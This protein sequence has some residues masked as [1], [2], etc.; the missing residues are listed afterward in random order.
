MCRANLSISRQS[1]R[2][3]VLFFQKGD[4]IS[5]FFFSFFFFVFLGKTQLALICIFRALS[6]KKH[7]TKNA[8]LF[9]WK[10]WKRKIWRRR[11]KEPKVAEEQSGAKAPTPFEFCS[12]LLPFEPK[13]SHLSNLYTIPPLSIVYYLLCCYCNGIEW[14]WCPRWLLFSKCSIY[15]HNGAVLMIPLQTRPCAHIL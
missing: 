5:F 9:G 2:A 13:I 12:N 10:A 14:H 1:L 3:F 6:P 11:K 8:N 4:S 7:K 15:R